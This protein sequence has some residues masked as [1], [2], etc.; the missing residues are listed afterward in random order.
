MNKGGT[1]EAAGHRGH[2]G[3]RRSLRRR[4]EPVTGGVRSTSASRSGFVVELEDGAAVYFAG[5]TDVFGDM[6]LIARAAQAGRRLPADR[7]ALHH[8]PARR[9][10]RGELLGVRRS[11]PSTTARSRPSQVRRS[12]C[13]PRIGVTRPRQR[14]GD[15][16]AARPDGGLSGRQG[17]EAGR[18]VRAVAARPRGRGRGPSGPRWPSGSRGRAGRGGRQ[19]REAGRAAAVVWAAGRGRAAAAEGTRSVADR[20]PKRAWTVG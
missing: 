15:R 16:A 14:G 8:G 18:A 3:P 4:L 7:R 1:V 6:A 11:C 10:E 13:G 2:D 17:R 12:S 20:R 5:D 9:R 19:G